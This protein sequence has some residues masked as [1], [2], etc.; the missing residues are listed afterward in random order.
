MRGLLAAALSLLINSLHSP[1][2]AAGSRFSGW[3]ADSNP[4]MQQHLA[5]AGAGQRS[6]VGRQSCECAQQALGGTLRL[7]P[8]PLSASVAAA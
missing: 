5:A 8:Q 3:N 1:Q 7:A 2:A 6:H 4:D